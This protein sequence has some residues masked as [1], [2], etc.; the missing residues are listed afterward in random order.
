MHI[1]EYCLLNLELAEAQTG[2]ISDRFFKGEKLISEYSER[3]F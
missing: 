2:Q 1:E 3:K